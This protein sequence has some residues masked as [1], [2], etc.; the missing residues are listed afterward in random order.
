MNDDIDTQLDTEDLSQTQSWE[1]QD[2]LYEHQYAVIPDSDENSPP[3][4]STMVKSEKR[5]YLDTSDEAQGAGTSGGKRKHDQIGIDVGSTGHNAAESRASRILKEENLLNEAIMESISRLI[6]FRQ[7]NAEA[8][9]NALRRKHEWKE[10][11]I[12]VLNE[13]IKRL[14]DTLRKEGIPLPEYPSASGAACWAPP[15]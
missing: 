11:K 9:H 13:W 12:R 15:S 4:M 5:R 2:Y 10:T 14:E 8:E 6:E 3:L 7:I 1:T